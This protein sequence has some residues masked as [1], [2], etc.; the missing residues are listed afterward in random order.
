MTVQRY[1]IS[2]VP[3][4][5][6][7]TD[8]MQITPNMTDRAK[9]IALL[10]KV[11]KDTLIVKKTGLE[12]VNLPT[13]VHNRHQII[14]IVSGTLHV[15]I[16]GI[17]YFATERHLVWIP[18]GVS[19]QLSSNNKAIELLVSYCCLEEMEDDRFG[20][21]N[22]N[23]L[24]RQNLHYISS[25]KR[26]SRGKTPMVF[27]FS[28]CFFRVLPT[29]CRK[30]SFPPLPVMSIDDQRLQPILEHIRLHM[31]EELSIQKVA[32]EFGFSVR[33]LTRLFTQA[34]S[35]FVYYLN[36]Q[37]IVRA[38]EIL[39]ERGTGIEQVAYEVGFHSPNSFSRVFKQITGDS[40]S[41][42]VGRKG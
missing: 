8:T 41:L 16:K 10:E 28:V 22:S 30:S 37:R 12:E 39:A 35:S 40:P 14:Y 42:Y 34:R 6:F 32:D 20:V 3:N 26:I 29:M 2:F 18:M 13:H 25:H 5:P 9:R 11:S 19:H 24:V 38:I 33:N 7:K 17:R 4:L 15:E 36:Y 23:E 27:Q 1:F 21:F 31:E